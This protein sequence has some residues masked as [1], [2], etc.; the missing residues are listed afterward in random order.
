MSIPTEIKAARTDLGYVIRVEGRGTLRESPA[1]REFAAQC[2]DQRRELT[3]SVDLSACEYLDS[4]FL[5]CLVGLYRRSQQEPNLRLAVCA[6]SETRRRLLGATRLDKLF[7]CVD[8][9]P[10]PAGPWVP[11]SA[12]E[13]EKRDFGLHVLE[14][15][16]RLS[17]LPGPSAAAFKAVADQ[18][19]RELGQTQP[20]KS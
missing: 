14:C 9:C 20:G 12:P 5:G 16:R 1:V 7:H 18:L 8:D 19:A 10:Q 17:E 3:L 13:L 4:T 11:L 6:E 15:H 2:L